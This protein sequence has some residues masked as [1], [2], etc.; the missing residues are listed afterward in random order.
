MFR[1]LGFTERR[2]ITASVRLVL[3]ILVRLIYSIES[4]QSRAS[5]EQPLSSSR[6]TRFTRVLS[7]SITLFVYYTHQVVLLA[8]PRAEGIVGNIG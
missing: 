2:F 1:F 6:Y 7:K 5:R 4:V 3:Y 8:S